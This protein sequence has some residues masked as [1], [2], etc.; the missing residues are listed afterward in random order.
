[1]SYITEAVTIKIRAGIKGKTRET[2]AKFHLNK[3]EYIFS[4][5]YH[6][7]GIQNSLV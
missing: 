6:S 2:Q 5:F 3:F 7:R 4:N 1:M